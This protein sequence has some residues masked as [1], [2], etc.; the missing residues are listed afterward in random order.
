MNDWEWKNDEGLLIS[1]QDDR[2]YRILKLSNGLRVLIIHD[3]KA[4][5]AAASMAVG[6]GASSDPDNLP[7]LA[8]FCEHML[9]LGTEKYPV[10]NTYK[11]FLNEK[12]G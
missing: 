4:K 6:V 3:K 9:F 10:E 7:G 8:H 5:K 1:P 2:Q 12:G 11:A